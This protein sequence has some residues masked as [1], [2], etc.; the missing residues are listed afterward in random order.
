MPVHCQ[1]ER[2]CCIG[3]AGTAISIIMI[4]LGHLVFS[5][6]TSPA[7]AGRPLYVLFVH[8]LVSSTGCNPK[9]KCKEV[10]RGRAQERVGCAL[11]A[12]AQA[13][14]DHAKQSQQRQVQ[15]RNLQTRMKPEPNVEQQQRQK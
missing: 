4:E 1:R 11:R 13:K 14:R 12:V 6:H 15:Q 5:G 3:G 8:T 7:G 2:W 10:E 9:H